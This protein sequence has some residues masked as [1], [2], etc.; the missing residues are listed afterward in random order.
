MLELRNLSFGDVEGF[1][2]GYIVKRSR[3][4]DGILFLLLG[5]GVLLLGKC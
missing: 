3:V 5:L 1:G 4:F 2:W